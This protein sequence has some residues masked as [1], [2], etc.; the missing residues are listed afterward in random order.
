MRKPPENPTKKYRIA[1]Y[2]L[3]AR[4]PDLI[5]NLQLGNQLNPPTLITKGTNLI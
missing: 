2:L 4:N 5:L 3:S 1:L